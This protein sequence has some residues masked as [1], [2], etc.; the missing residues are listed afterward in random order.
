MC[1]VADSHASTQVSCLQLSILSRRGP[2][3][4]FPMIDSCRCPFAYVINFVFR[5]GRSSV[6]GFC[7]HSLLLPSLLSTLPPLG[8]L[9][10]EHTTVKCTFSD[11]AGCDLCGIN[12]WQVLWSCGELD[13]LIDQSLRVR[14]ML[15]APIGPYKFPLKF[16]L[17][18]ISC[19]SRSLCSLPCFPVV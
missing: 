18:T 11:F 17:F 16:F 19:S 2:A 7:I 14:D 3:T 4:L 13:L 15:G 6:H 8:S 10:Y 12:V 5:F 9:R 1:G